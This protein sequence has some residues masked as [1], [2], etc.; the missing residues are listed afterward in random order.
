[1]KYRGEGRSSLAGKNCEDVPS[2]N[3]GKTIEKSVV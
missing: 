1:M 3:E 2:N